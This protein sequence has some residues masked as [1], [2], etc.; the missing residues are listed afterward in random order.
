MLQ[1]ETCQGG[2]EPAKKRQKPD[3]AETIIVRVGSDQK[4]YTVH[5]AM[6]CERSPFFQGATS[7]QWLESE[8]KFV[9]LP[10]VEPYIF[11]SWIHA[12]YSGHIDITLFS[13]K[14]DHSPASYEAMF[15]DLAKLWVLADM[16]LD[17]GLC[18]HLV[19]MLINMSL[20]QRTIPEI[21]TLQYVYVH[22]AKDSPLRA[23]YC[24][25]WANRC[26][27]TEFE[28]NRDEIPSDL[29]FT[30]AKYF[31]QQSVQPRMN[32]SNRCGYHIHP[33]GPAMTCAYTFANVV[34]MEPQD[35]GTRDQPVLLID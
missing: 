12:L 15:L 13:G 34:D 33:N 18:D 28:E 27:H 16:L 31:L 25:I 24:D 9:P 4:D 21:T 29:I 7:G 11:E 30:L 10:T 1:R 8:E 5:K 17:H 20:G 23:L 26:T 14:D 22:T 3:Y 2:G 6:L 19:D 32:F 35:G